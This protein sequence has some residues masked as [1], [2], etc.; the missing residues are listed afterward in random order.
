MSEAE[1]AQLLIDDL[2][3]HG[4][5]IFK[6]VC[7]SGSNIRCDCFLVKR[8][9]NGMVVESVAIETKTT[10]SLKVINQAYLWMPHANTVYVGVPPAKRSESST[11]RFALAVCKK[12]GIGVYEVWENGRVKEVV[13]PVSNPSPALPVLYEQQKDYSAGNDTSSY[14][15]AFKHTIGQFNRVMEQKGE[16]VL[17]NDIIA[18][19]DHHYASPASARSTMQKYIKT[20]VIPGYRI[21]KI[22]NKL[23]VCVSADIITT[24]KRR[25]KRSR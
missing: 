4:Y 8:D 14:Y 19:I 11:R 16:R 20:G 9:G 22:E 23:W 10:F 1:L 7:A 3:K 12:F 21:E 13:A 5:E 2:E 25:K 17:L 6:E 15:T 24:P 18:E